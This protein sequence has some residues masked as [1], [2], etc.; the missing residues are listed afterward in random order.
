MIHSGEF[1]LKL[2]TFNNPLTY[3]LSILLKKASDKKLYPGN[4][5]FSR[6]TKLIKGTTVINHHPIYR[7]NRGSWIMHGI[8][9][10]N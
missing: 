2:L 1:P 6:L 9:D 7:A 5:N 3:L 10:D 4:Y 8:L